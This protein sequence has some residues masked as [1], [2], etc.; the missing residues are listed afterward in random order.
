MPKIYQLK[1]KIMEYL[2]K[3]IYALN[4]IDDDS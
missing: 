3:K 2:D 4:N 1:F